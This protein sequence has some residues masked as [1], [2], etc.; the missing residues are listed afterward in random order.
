MN[1]KEVSGWVRLCKVHYVP[2]LMIT[3]ESM[4]E[5]EMNPRNTNDLPSLILGAKWKLV[6]ELR[7]RIR[8]EKINFIKEEDRMYESLPAALNSYVEQDLVRQ[9]K[10]YDKTTSRASAIEKVTDRAIEIATRMNQVSEKS[11]VATTLLRMAELL[12]QSE[13][14]RAELQAMN[15]TF[16]KIIQELEKH[17]PDMLRKLFVQAAEEK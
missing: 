3:V 14:N 7:S 6:S 11:E 9:M 5:N 16:F 17:N 2:N 13:F 1:E 4:G 8:G 10:E 15:S 12:R